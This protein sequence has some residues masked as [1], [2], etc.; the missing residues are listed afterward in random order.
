MAEMQAALAGG[1]I[2]VRFFA[3]QDFL[4][5]F[6]SASSSLPHAACAEAPVSSARAI[7]PT[8]TPTP[9]QGKWRH[10]PYTYNAQKRIKYHHAG[11]WRL[12]EVHI[13]HFGGRGGVGG[14]AGGGSVNVGARLP[15]PAPPPP[16]PAHTHLRSG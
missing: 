15:A 3:E 12:E 10:L 1:R 13:I 9:P 11:L 2:P 5:G 14:R 6:Y 7:P 4:N 16:L 8:P